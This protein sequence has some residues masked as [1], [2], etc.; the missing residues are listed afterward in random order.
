MTTLDNFAI[1]MLRMR[2]AASTEKQQPWICF[3]F[4]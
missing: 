4:V 3:D 1:F 2:L